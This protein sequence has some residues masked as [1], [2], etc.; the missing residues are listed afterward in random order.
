[1]LEQATRLDS[2]LESARI[3][4]PTDALV[5]IRT[6]SDNGALSPLLKGAV[7]EAAQFDAPVQAATGRLVYL[8]TFVILS[9]FGASL[10]MFKILTA[11]VKIFQDFKTDLPPPTQILIKT[12]AVLANYGILGLA[13]I[14]LVTMLG[15]VLLRYA[16]VLQWDHP[17]MRYFTR[18]LDEAV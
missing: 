7:R 9:A 11:Y 1:S 5:A 15:Y 18:P 14:A 6:G 13:S 10:L 8:M 2:A 17:F 16:G 12:F 4:L 3:R